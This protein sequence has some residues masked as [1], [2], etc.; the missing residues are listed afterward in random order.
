M[1]KRTQLTSAVALM[2]V[3]GGCS[4]P[5]SHR[6][7]DYGLRIPQ[8]RLN[9]VQRLTLNDYTLP[10]VPPEPPALP[11]EPAPAP[12]EE[13]LRELT[14]E[15]SRAWVLE[16][17]LDLRVSLIEPT[18][19]QENLSQEEAAFDWVIRA[20]GRESRTDQPTSSEL[21]GSQTRSTTFTPG[22]RIPL[23]T[24]GTADVSLPI[25]RFETDNDFSTLD[26]AWN[27]DLLLSISQPLLRNAGRRTATHPIRI[28]ALNSQITL[29]QTKLSVIRTLAAADRAYWDL[30]AAGK[31]LEVRQREYELAQEQLTRAER[32]L[33]AGDV[34]N[35]EVIRARSGVADRLEAIIVADTARKRAERS[36]KRLI[37][38]P[39]LPVGGPQIVLPATSPDPDYQPLDGERLAD[40]GVAQ[41]IE[42]LELELQLAQDASTI[43]FNKNQ[44]LPSFVLDYQYRINGLGD[45]LSGALDQTRT[46]EF[47][48]WSLG[49]NFEVPIGNFAAKARTHASII[50]RLQRLSTREARELQI[51]EEVLN[52]LDALDSAWQ[53]ILASGQRA[54]LAGE[55]LR[56]E[57]NQ[58]EVGLRTSTDVLDAATRLGDAQAAEV[59]ALADY[60]IALVDLAFATGTV[61]GASKVDFAPLDP[62][63]PLGPQEGANTRNP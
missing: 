31:T 10:P 51:R 43:D 37:N 9:T 33:E 11:G 39:D 48:D 63:G 29:A 44:Q 5:F 35:V 36:L 52:A 28:A 30:Y 50:R 55:T 24:G 58:F 14:L 27:A 42:M 60:Q 7:S 23:R 22:V 49:F 56:A 1:P 57:Q 19:A 40:L 15:Q 34:A 8:E 54:V 4:S 3:V 25:S 17:N 21:D 53:R 18:I 47:A 46:G 13:A 62:R 41:R 45:T 16:N 2:L 59:R 12:T 20:S 61:M 32:R 26:T 6:E 38:H